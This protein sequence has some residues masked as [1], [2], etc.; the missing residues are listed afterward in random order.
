MS[1]PFLL[2]KVAVVTGGGS[3]IGEAAARLLA[4]AGARVAILDLQAE[5]GESAAQALRAAG[6]EAR[7][8]QTDMTSARAVETALQAI[9]QVYPEIDI[10]VNVAGGSGRRFGD[11]PTAECT[12]QGWDAT[13]D[14]NLK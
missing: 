5:K 2:D 9:L 3:G 11:G 13:L 8:I 7:F 12:E 1:D 4:Q 10:W 6:G 14:L